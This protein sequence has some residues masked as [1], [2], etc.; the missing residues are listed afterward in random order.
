MMETLVAMQTCTDDLGKERKFQYWLITRHTFYEGQEYP[1][2][3]VRITEL[4]GE[5]A[6]IP[7]LTVDPVRMD[8]LMKLLIGSCVTPIDLP[9]VIED[10]L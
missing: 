10:W 2:Y 9:Y 6:V 3:G 8:G 7:S 1:D 4:E 5:T